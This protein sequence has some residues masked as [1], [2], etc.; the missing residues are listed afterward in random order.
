MNTAD[1]MEENQHHTLYNSGT[2][3]SLASGVSNIS[4]NVPST[5]VVNNNNGGGENIQVF[6]RMRPLN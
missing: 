6:L 3:A 2:V 4:D 1:I 5:N